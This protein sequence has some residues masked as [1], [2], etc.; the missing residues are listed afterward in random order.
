MVNVYRVMAAH[1]TGGL[2]E[3]FQADGSLGPII[4]ILMNWMNC[5]KP[6]LSNDLRTH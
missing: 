4:Y 6:R 2:G 3:N 5:P 1:S